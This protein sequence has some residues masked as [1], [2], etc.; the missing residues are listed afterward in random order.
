MNKLIIIFLVFFVSITTKAQ[1][2][3]E[4]VKSDKYIYSLPDDNFTGFSKYN[5]VD[6]RLQPDEDMVLFTKVNEKF[7]ALLGSTS[8]L[9]M[10]TFNFDNNGN[11]LNVKLISKTKLDKNIVYSFLNEL[12]SVKTEIDPNSIN[13]EFKNKSFYV[14]YNV[15]I[16]QTL[17][18]SGWVTFIF[19]WKMNCL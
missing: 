13:S 5:G 2:A 10:A 14:S 4:V 7:K 9:S 15:P 1:F 12:K 18:A 6:F 19:F 8:S 3:I 17:K 11:V 16:K